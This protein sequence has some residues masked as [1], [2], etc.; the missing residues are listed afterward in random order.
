MVDKTVIH[1]F[2]LPAESA[3]IPRL[4]LWD[5]NF[6]VAENHK[7]VLDVKSQCVKIYLKER[8][9]GINGE[10]LSISE[11]DGCNLKIKGKILSIEYLT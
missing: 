4:S 8:L 3:G 2:G 7:G 6:L 1:S 10:N 5:D 11:L 9:V